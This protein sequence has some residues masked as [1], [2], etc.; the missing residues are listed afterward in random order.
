MRK[1]IMTIEKVA[2]RSV[3][4][5]RFS[6]NSMVSSCRRC[7]PYE[8]LARRKSI[9][10]LATAFTLPLFNRHGVARLVLAFIGRSKESCKLF[11]IMCIQLIVLID[12]SL[13]S[14]IFGNCYAL[15]CLQRDNPEAQKWL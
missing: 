10:N 4:R 6:C 14:K 3:V 9:D 13:I 5:I 8:S 11:F 12:A 15:I 7:A 1:A 2:C